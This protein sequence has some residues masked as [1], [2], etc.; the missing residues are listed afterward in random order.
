MLHVLNTRPVDRAKALSCALQQ[1]G[2]RVTEFPLLQLNAFALGEPLTQ[3]LQQLRS[4]HVVIVA[5]PSAAQ[6][7]LD[8]LNQLG[9]KVAGL[10]LRWIAVGEGTADVL[11]QA[12]VQPS[13]P[14]IETSEGV[15]DLQE[16]AG[17]T[18]PLKVM[19]WR[20]VGG[21][22]LMLNTLE[23]QGHILH[24]LALY[25]RR[26]APESIQH[27][28]A[29]SADMPDVLLISSGE[30]WRYW[31]QLNQSAT[32][33]NRQARYIL[34]LGQRVYQQVCDDVLMMGQSCDVIKLQDL[35]P[36]SILSAL[37]AL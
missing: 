5:S 10:A 4:M 24:S 23:S 27:Y 16:L 6:I 14:A 2:Y 13:V 1:A 11:R 19:I 26:L 25:E 7:G 29:L 32:A 3:A 36:D 33:F 15:L 20:G 21:R 22:Q 31:Q 35:R 12:G 30:S 9:I 18:H 8:Y 34:V 37:A 28:R 17:V